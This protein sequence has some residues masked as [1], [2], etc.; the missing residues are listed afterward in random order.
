[1]AHLSRNNNVAMRRSAQG[2]TLIELM[3]VVAVVGI[4]FTFA[5]PAYQNSVI[6]SKRATAK[7]L[8]MDVANR[9]ERLLLDRST[10]TLDMQD[11]GFSADPTISDDGNYSVDAAA[12][13]GGTIANCYVLTATARS[14]QA[15]D[16]KCL[17][18]T[19]DSTGAKTAP[20]AECW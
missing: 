19:L 13:A 12:C 18:L 4:L 9:Q 1:M 6:K 16:S 3:I 2:F 17:T 10:Y 5:L 7:S 14:G 20:N 11:L 15:K 8:L